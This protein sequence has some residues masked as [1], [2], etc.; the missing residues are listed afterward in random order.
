MISICLPTLNAIRFLKE[1]IESIFAQTY[2]DWE[3]IVCDSYSDDGTWEYMEQYS[4]DP[5][6]R[7]FRVPKEGLYAGWNECLRRVRG[8]FIYIATADDT[9][10]SD[11]L[12]KLVEALSCN[13]TCDVAVCD[14][15]EI[16]A[17]SNP[18]TK[19]HAW[20][21]RFYGERLKQRHIRPRLQE[22]LTTLI[23]GTPWYTMTAVLLR[24]R[25]LDRC[26]LFPTDIGFLGDNVWTARVA[27]MTD[28]VYV[29]E[30]LATFR[31]HGS[32]AS[33][34]KIPPMMAWTSCLAFMTLIDEFE[35]EFPLLWKCSPRWKDQLM[36]V[37]IALYRHSLG[38]Y[39]WRLRSDPKGFTANLIA[40][41][42]TQPIWLASHAFRGFPAAAEI[43]PVPLAHA[44]IVRFTAT[45]EC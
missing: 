42:R 31:R 26:G 23:I 10:R 5:R 32:Q 9:M 21:R 18:V 39:R 15:D 35:D 44:L 28:V 22:F 8:E 17:E 40:A 12:E 36:E 13:L 24:A 43:D 29:P 16:D 30:R 41:L 11:C 33:G 20:H 27:L 2:S 25:L 45:L 34:Q 7:L 19:E 6:V 38:L 1:R 4:R 37:Q 3:L 14:F